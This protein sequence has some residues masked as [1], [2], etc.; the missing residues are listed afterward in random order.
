MKRLKAGKIKKYKF[1]QKIKHFKKKGK[2]KIEKK[3]VSTAS[4]KRS[5]DKRTISR[6][7][8]FTKDFPNKYN[9]KPTDGRYGT[10]DPLSPRVQEI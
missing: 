8:P 9:N 6:P 5:R 2:E 1:F 3:I 7:T 4:V 10:I